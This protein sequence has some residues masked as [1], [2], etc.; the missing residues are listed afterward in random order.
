MKL[1]NW[2]IFLLCWAVQ[3]SKKNC[4]PTHDVSEKQAKAM[5]Q[6]AATIGHRQILAYRYKL[7]IL[8]LNCLVFSKL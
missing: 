6:R 1:N 5:R 4:Q 3:I 8:A 2:N 7:I